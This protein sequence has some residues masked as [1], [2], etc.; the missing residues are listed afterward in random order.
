MSPGLLAF[1]SDSG[2][3]GCRA[4]KHFWW[5]KDVSEGSVLLGQ[6][7][8]WG[9]D[10]SCWQ[11]WWGCSELSQSPPYFMYWRA[12]VLFPAISEHCT[13]CSLLSSSCLSSY[14]WV[15]RRWHP[16]VV[17]QRGLLHL[18][19]RLAAFICCLSSFLLTDS[20]RMVKIQISIISDILL[21]SCTN[22]RVM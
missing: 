17:C 1:G 20:W 14:L 5:Q 12:L 22:L 6:S 10:V 16:W 9:C 3:R 19:L 15:L 2:F 13:A 11:R 18:Y 8:K 21:D 7:S 4:P